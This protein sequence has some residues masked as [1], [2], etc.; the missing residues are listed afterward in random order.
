MD[1]IMTITNFFVEVI[2]DSTLIKLTTK[3]LNGAV[4]IAII[5]SKL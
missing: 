1:I 2:F 5:C 4:S 3:K